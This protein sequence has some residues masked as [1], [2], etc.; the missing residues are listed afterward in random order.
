M[1]QKLPVSRLVQTSLQLTPVASPS[2]NLSTLLILGTS[3]VIDVTQRMREYADLTEVGQDF[4]VTDE[5][6]LAAQIWFGQDPTPDSV[7]IGRWAKTATPGILQCGPLSSANSQIAAWNTIADGSFKIAVD[8]GVSTLVQALN[9]SAAANLNAIAADITTAMATA[10]VAATCQYNASTNNFEFLTT[11]TGP[12]ATCSF[13]TAGTAGTDL[14]DMLAGLATS[15]GAY[16]ANG[17]AAETALAAVQLFDDQFAGQWYGLAVPSSSAT[18]FAAIAAYLEADTNIPHFQ[19][20]TSQDA[21]CLLASSTT[22]VMYLAKLAAYTRSAIQYSSTSVY[23][24]ISALAKILTTDWEGSGT[25]ITLMFKTE[26]LITPENLSTTQANAIDG[27]NGNVYASYNDGSAN[28][29]TG[30][31]PSGQYIDTVIGCDWL[32][33]AIQTACYDYMRQVPKVPQTDSGMH[34]LATVIES[35]CDKAV[36]NGLAAPGV[37]TGPSFGQLKTGQTLAKGYYVYCPPISSQSAA[38]RQARKSVP[39]QVALKLAGAVQSVDVLID[40]NP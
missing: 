22:D 10:A 29:Q 28:F 6:Y 24:M 9:F 18:D 27:K 17:I 30:I 31:T 26:P 20:F 7:N 4:G 34:S 25:T 13:L 21:N 11:Q 14:S 35:V 23:A 38:D 15:P 5:E 16:L 8:G 19:E 39:I 36:N 3:P 12:T 32:R 1:T 2:P 33:L 40:V 37:W